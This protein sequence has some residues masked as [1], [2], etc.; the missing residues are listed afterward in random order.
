[1]NMMKRFDISKERLEELHFARN[2]TLKEMAEELG[3]S[4]STVQRRLREYHIKL[5]RGN[6]KRTKALGTCEICGKQIEKLGLKK[7]CNECSQQVRRER[8]KEWMREYRKLHP[9]KKNEWARS[10]KIKVLRHYSQSEEPFCEC[11]GE[12]NIEFLTIDHV[13]GGGTQHRRQL[14]ENGMT[15]YRWLIKNNF[16]PG[17][18]VLCM[19][20]NT[21]IGFYGY[22]PHKQTTEEL[23]NLRKKMFLIGG[24]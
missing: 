2:L 22:C 3:V 6:W 19:N 7:Y 14:R 8:Q 13:N 9:E 5:R 15:I 20:C 23:K 1:M 4:V 18:R 17:Y 10:M 21:S 24:D 12:N 16:P 11:C